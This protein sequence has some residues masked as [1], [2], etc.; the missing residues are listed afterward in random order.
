MEKVRS[1]I[2]QLVREWSSNG[3]SERDQSYQLIIDQLL[4]RL[5]PTSRSDSQKPRVLVPGCGLGRLAWEIV[6]LGLKI[7]NYLIIFDLFN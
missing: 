3:K 4:Q 5:P 2:R 6:R 7:D 1:T